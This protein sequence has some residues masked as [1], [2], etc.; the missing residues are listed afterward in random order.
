MDPIEE[1][2]RL[3]T[4]RHFFSVSSG[5]LGTAALASLL[6]ADAQA[7]KGLPGLP[8]FSAKAKRVIYLFQHGAPSQL[9]LFDYKPGLERAR[10][11]DLPESIRMGQRLTGMTA[12]Q[13]SF[14]TAPSIFRFSQHGQSGLWLSELL[15]HTARV[16]DRIAILRSM[17]T[18]AINHD[19]AVTFFQTGFQLAGRPSIGSWIS[20]GLGSE[21][22]DL[23]AF[24]VM[25]SQGKGGSQALADRQWG[26]GFLSTRYQGVKFRSG[27][28]PVLYLSNPAGYE[29]PARRRFLDDLGRLN[30]LEFKDYQDPEISTRIAQY[31]M[32]YRMQSS[33]PELTDLSKEPES[34][35]ALYGPDS[36]QPGSYAA[37]CILAR[38]LAE[39]GV[40][41]IQ[42][43]HR[44]WDQHNN[45]PREI[46]QQCQQTDQPT[47]ALIQDLA[48][49]GM[50]D[51]TLVVWGGEFG[52]TVYSQGAL[53]QDNYGRDH[54]PRCFSMWLAG[55]GVK[56]GLTHGETD[57][58]SYNIVRD[59]V[60]VHDLHA[61]ILHCLGVDHTRLTFKFQG[62]H[63]R[64]TD[65]HGNVV[66]GILA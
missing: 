11:A 66:R 61:T 26:S 52:R 15:P 54:H 43:F 32:A 55:G 64:L 9:D 39:R 59:P 53:T 37:N 30:E 45:L 25:V 40:R 36:R 19:P 57:D 34:T 31:E 5:G 17:R 23:P 21:N 62:R 35:F 51:D 56:G 44:G 58:F 3:L 60:E 38:R 14:P 63:Y 48:Q 41:F 7:A 27:A 46:R 8:H 65:V 24:V 12:Y 29:D 49:R 6:A 47:A 28:D 42:L 18:E 20:Y 33:V 13:S 1:R 10:G 4:R 22:Q 16:A 2:K 50:L